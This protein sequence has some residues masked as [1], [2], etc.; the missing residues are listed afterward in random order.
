MVNE[1][2][3]DDNEN[4]YPMYKQD[5]DGVPAAAAEARHP[6]ASGAD[7]KGEED[8]RDVQER[9]AECPRTQRA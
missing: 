2:E 6:A 9:M 4:L 5:P 7:R 8:A 1:L 3:F